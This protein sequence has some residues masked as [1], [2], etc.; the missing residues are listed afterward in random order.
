MELNL[1]LLTEKIE[2]IRGVLYNLINGN[3]KLTDRL[4]VDCSQQLDNLLTEYEICKKSVYPND[5]A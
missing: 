4:I 5:A 3:H 2:K 1:Q